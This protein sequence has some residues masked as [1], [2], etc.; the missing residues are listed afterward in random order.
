M[1]GAVRQPLRLLVMKVCPQVKSDAQEEQ[2]QTLKLV[3]EWAWLLYILRYGF[4][5]NIVNR[6][7]ESQAISTH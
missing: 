3:E 5:D 1:G 2:R 6:L 7:Q 4:F